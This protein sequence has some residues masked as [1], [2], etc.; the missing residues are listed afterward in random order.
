MFDALKLDNDAAATVTIAGHLHSVQPSPKHSPFADV[1]ILGADF[2][3]DHRLSFVP[4]GGK[5]VKYVFGLQ[6]YINGTTGSKPS[7][8]RRWL[9]WDTN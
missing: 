9:Q 1:N 5:E 8:W 3:V 6:D 2:C 7:S 4:L